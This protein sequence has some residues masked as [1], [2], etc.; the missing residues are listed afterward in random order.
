MVNNII[1]IVTSF[2][3][4]IIIVA[5]DGPVPDASEASAVPMLSNNP[6]IITLNGTQAFHSLLVIRSV[7][8]GKTTVTPLLTHWSYCSLALSH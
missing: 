7:A 4:Y 3:I 2:N 5:A 1:G 6:T 8:H